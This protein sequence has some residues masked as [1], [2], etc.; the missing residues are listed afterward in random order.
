MHDVTA[1]LLVVFAATGVRAVFGFADALVAMPLLAVL[2]GLR[3]ATPLVALMSLTNALV[4]WL[5][6]RTSFDWRGA[7]R[8][9]AATVAGIPVGLLLLKG[10]DEPFM[11]SALAV[12]LLAFSAYNLIRPGIMEIRD[13]SWGY[14]FG[15]VS[16]VLGGAYN[17]N[18][19]V[20]VMYAALRRWPPD[21][22][23]ATLNG[24]FFLTGMFI[25]AGHGAA[26]LWTGQVVR[27]YLYA[28]PV[29]AAAIAAGFLIHK[30]I[31][32]E[33]FSAAVYVLLMLLGVYLL[34][35]S[36]G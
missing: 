32:A 23:R 27:L 17:T 21:S 30:R 7:L 18:G 10:V 2:L 12:L 22:F 4:I 8:L 14:L 36:A 16:G 5:R 28:L 20:V 35:Q 15:L 19:P 1:V 31:P 26:G 9:I 24:Y 13:D 11:K 3:T 34:A 6:H 25:V 29:M 33:K